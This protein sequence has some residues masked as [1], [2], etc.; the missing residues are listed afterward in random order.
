LSP[1]LVEAER[2]DEHRCGCGASRRRFL[3]KG[4]RTKCDSSEHGQPRETGPPPSPRVSASRKFL[5]SVCV[6]TRQPARAGESKENY[7]VGKVAGSGTPDFTNRV[8]SEH[9]T[10]GSPISC[11]LSLRA[12]CAGDGEMRFFKSGLADS[13]SG[14]K[15]LRSPHSRSQVSIPTSCRGMEVIKAWIEANP[16]QEAPCTNP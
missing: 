9:L 10:S 5:E 13:P 7:C 14:S 3:K 6:T 4:V 12:I 8:T 11:N 2:K 15:I 1:R 16:T